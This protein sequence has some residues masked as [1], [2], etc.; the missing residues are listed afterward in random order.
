VSGPL[1]MGLEDES[2]L[3]PWG[4]YRQRDETAHRRGRTVREFAQRHNRGV[5]TVSSLTRK[6][7]CH[8]LRVAFMNFG[9][10]AATKSLLSSGQKIAPLCGRARKD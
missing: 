10:F 7:E 4:C 3:A 5:Q 1:G 9:A 2:A 6:Q 8:E